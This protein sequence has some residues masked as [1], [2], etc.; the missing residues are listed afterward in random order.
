M[1]LILIFISQVVL[2]ACTHLFSNN[3]KPIIHSGHF[4]NSNLSQEKNEEVLRVME[5]KN[6]GL[7]N[8]TLDDLTIATNQ[9]IHFENFPRLI[10]LNSSITDL[11][12]DELYSGPNV[13]PYYV[14]NGVCFLG[15]SDNINNSKLPSEHYII[16]DYVV[17]ILKVKQQSQKANPSS[18]V[19]IHKLG[20]V[21]K[22]ISK[23]L[24]EEFRD[25]LT[26]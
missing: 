14:L 16:N 21:F 7:I 11:E 12:T 1:K 25:L 4:L 5:A 6:Y 19:V 22:E 24:P 9:N 17:S 13:V 8:L 23:R 3:H 10:F 2:I 18:Y 26:D 15:L 20:N